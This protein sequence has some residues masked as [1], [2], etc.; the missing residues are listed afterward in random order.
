[1]K[2]KPIPPKLADYKHIT[3]STGFL[4]VLRVACKKIAPAWP[5]ENFVAVNPYLG[6]TDKTFEN[7]ASEL[8]T[9]GSI[10]TTLPVSFYL[11]KIEDSFISHDDLAS[12]LNTKGHDKISDIDLFI[13]R[14]RKME[15]KDDQTGVVPT[16]ADVAS[17]TCKQ[18]WSRFATSRI[19]AWA[20]SYFDKG[21]ALWTAA[22]QSKSLFSSWKE[23]AEIDL[24]P[25]IMGLNG[26][27]SL[28]KK[29]PED[30]LQAAQLALNKLNIPEAL[31]PYYL[32]RLL[33][34]TGGWS[35]YIARLDFDSKLY[36]KSEELLTEF[37][38]VLLVWEYCLLQSLENDLVLKNWRIA[39]SVLS[40][41]L[42]KK[43]L[44]TQLASKLVLQQAFEL[45]TQRR[46]IQTFQQS[47][48]T[49]VEKPKRSKVQAVFCIDVRSEVFRRN[50][51]LADEDIETLG[52]AGFFAFPV[53]HVPLGYEDGNAQCPV[54]LKPTATILETIPHER[55]HQ[56]AVASRIIT[57]QVNGLWKSFKSGAVSCFGFV[58]PLG[59]FYLP[60]L[61]TDSF[62]LSRPVPHPA[63]VGLKPA[64]TSQK[65]LSLVPSYF[66]DEITG[67]SIEQQVKLAKNAL[68]AMSLCDNFARLVLIVGHG[69]ASVNN[70]HASGLDCGAC[71]GNTGEANAKL[72]AEVLNNPIV[73]FALEP[74]GIFIPADTLFLACLHNTTTDEVTIYNEQIVPADREA[75]LNDLKTKLECAGKA[76]RAERAS[77]MWLKKPENLDSAVLSRSKDW[78]Q[79]RPEWGLAGCYAFIVAPRERTK[80]INLKG[81]SFLHTYHWEKDTDFSI[82]ELIMTAPMVVTSWI[83]LQYYGSTVDNKNFGSGNKT[84]HNVTAG[85]GIIEGSSGDLRIG[86][87]WQSVHDGQKYQHEPSR[88]NVIIEAPV[89]AVNNVLKKHE[90]VRQ[91]CD[92]QWIHLLTLNKVGKIS[93]RYTGNYTWEEIA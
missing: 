89:E 30:Y 48:T 91:L 19:S 81:R 35:A 87:P 80:G 21:Q 57:Q 34:N 79:V 86:L 75:E 7:A 28:V 74:D 27:R 37:L 1:M 23:E 93:K 69:S 47:P 76:S 14:M 90:S 3:N 72:A 78:S 6:L 33:L 42:L 83:S 44:S 92:N 17:Q 36:G 62:G 49:F 63:K 20:A 22:D 45:A 64:F 50:L 70:P 77:R 29:L 66:H 8:A 67:M 84:L 26:F 54:L 59:L 43:E 41:T 18:D 58:S 16:A 38:S 46:L 40:Q 4:E 24:S 10:Q 65:S 12:V 56:K 85:L 88:L 68:K 5:L 51:E 73:K 55:T 52:F 60:K 82:L 25:E 32:H 2:S 71:G 13:K 53:K 31:I 61:F 15:E 39:L 11:Q 9:A